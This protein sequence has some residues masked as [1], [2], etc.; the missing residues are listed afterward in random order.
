MG[1]K[2]IEP[3]KQKN[4]ITREGKKR[5]EEELKHLVEVER[6]RVIVEIRD[7]RGLGDL[8]ENAEYSVARERQG[9]I[10]DRIREINAILDNS[11]ILT[12]GASHSTKSKNEEVRIGC[13]LVLEHLKNGSRQSYK[14]VGTLEADP[15]SQP[16][17][18]VSYESP[19]AQAV[20]GK[21]KGDVVEVD[22]RQKYQVKIVAVKN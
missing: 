1:A 22:G 12:T 2:M 14:I 4:L 8:S 15:F 13:E 5:L 18:K 11:Q 6:P 20:L 16:L 3:P 17:V 10:E 7:A 9:K 19:L 21:H